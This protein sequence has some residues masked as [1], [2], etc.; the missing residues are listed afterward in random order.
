MKETKDKEVKESH[1]RDDWWIEH[2]ENGLD[3]NSKNL[4]EDLDLLL[5]N[6]K[7]GRKLLDSLKRTRQLL[8]ESDDVTLPES[9]FVYRDLHNKIMMAI[10]EE[11][12]V[13]RA[14]EHRRSSRSSG[15]RKTGILSS[16]KE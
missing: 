16:C 13:P 9:G 11:T 8:K 10:E 14:P 3:K 6:S 2:L 7:S 15:A 12:E 1:Y 5:E 4:K